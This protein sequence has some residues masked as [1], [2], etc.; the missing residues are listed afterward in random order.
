M[1][2]VYPKSEAFRRLLDEAAGFPDVLILAPHERVELVS[3]EL[4]G[5]VPD[6][7]HHFLLHEE[8]RDVER[9]M[10]EDTAAAAHSEPRPSGL[11]AEVEAPWPSRFRAVFHP[12]EVVGRHQ[13]QV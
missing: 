3:A 9:R 6:T 5:A 12:L 1:P 11:F 2:P 13:H 4:F 8:M 7:A 10:A